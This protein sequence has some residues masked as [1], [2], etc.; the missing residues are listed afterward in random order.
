MTIKDD[1][2]II[3]FQGE[4]IALGPLSSEY[5]P[6]YQKWNND[7]IVTRATSFMGPVTFEAQMDAFSKTED[8][9]N[10]FF[11]IFDKSS[12]L[13]IGITYLSNISKRNADFAIKA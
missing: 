1:Q 9:S 12:L 10:V 6:L 11:T 3:N 2:P 4:K 13:P 7:F 8:S 5:N